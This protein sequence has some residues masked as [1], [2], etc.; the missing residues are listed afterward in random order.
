MGD[1]GEV[2]PFRATRHGVE[3]RLT[4]AEVDFLSQVP[5]LLADVGATRQ[6]PVYLD[7]PDANAEWWR[8]MGGELSGSRNADR[9]AYSLLLEAAVEGTVASIAEAEAFLRVLVEG[10][11]ALAARLGVLSATDYDDLAPEDLAALDY[12]AQ[13]QALLISA[14]T[15]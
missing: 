2:K 8:L 10:R 11:L 14:L 7:D 6:A 13:V 4:Q 5:V 1:T 3:I 9:S 15:R 12:L